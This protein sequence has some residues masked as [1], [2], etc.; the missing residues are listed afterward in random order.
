MIIV[1][2][3]LR[4]LL[5]ED[6]EDDATMTLHALK[7]SGFDVASERVQT[8]D[9]M[10]AALATQS[11]DVIVSDYSMPQFTGPEAFQ[12]LR[13]VG[14]D[15]PF[16]IVSGTVGE[17]SAVQAMRMGVHDYLLKGNLH[18]L[19]PALERELRDCAERKARMQAEAARQRAETSLRTTEEQL[20]HAQKMEA[21]GRLAGGIAHDFNNILS[22][23]L[24]Y[25][26]FAIDVLKPGDPMRDDLETVRGAGERAADLTRQLLAFSRQ[27]VLEPRVMDL[28]KIVRAIEKMLA[29][30][31]GEDVSV[32][33][34]PVLDS[35]KIYADPGQVE[36]VIMNLVVNA[37]DAMPRGGKITVEINN[38]ELDDEYAAAHPSVTAGSYVM[39]AVTDTGVGMDR[40]TQARI[41]EPFF[42]TKEVGKGTGLGL[43]TVYGIVQQS[44]G[45]IWLYSEPGQ[46]TT[47]RVYFPRTDKEAVD[48]RTPVP[49]RSLHG[50][51]TVLVVED[52]DQVRAI[53]SSVLRRNGYTVLEAHN[54][55][56]ALQLCESHGEPIDLVVTDVIMPTMGGKELAERILKLR[57]SLKV[58]FVS[59][60]TENTIIHH[61]VLERG[62]AFLQKP[63]TPK[64]FATKVREVLER[65]PRVTS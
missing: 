3:P 54:G 21:V 62:I 56:A 40:A 11:W 28:A 14:L 7:R 4:V 20:R 51:E 53:M 36:Q 65:G 58:L 44:K 52:E 22:V 35:G 2:T 18:R 63:I 9:D 61:G 23:I 12:T 32:S 13:E 24:S 6:S 26:T 37:R 46:G 27:Q 8:R 64:A 17:E 15:I 47:F 43:S 50:T 25:T 57:P 30:L 55:L 42:T 29:R 16:V 31:V 1:G 48:L 34:M 59:G 39:L 19:G 41:F 60:Y 5:V 33:V 10:R 45:H 49:P 38:A